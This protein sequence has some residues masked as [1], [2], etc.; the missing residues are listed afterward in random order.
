MRP[1]FLLAL[2][3]LLASCSDRSKQDERAHTASLRRATLGAVRDAAGPLAPLLAPRATSLHREG[4]AYVAGS[5][6]VDDLDVRIGAR[7]VAVA[8]GPSRRAPIELSLLDARTTDVSLEDGHVVTTGVF[9]A[10]DRVVSFYGAQVEEW[11]LLR[12]A[13]APRELRWSLRA[14]HVTRGTEGELLVSDDRGNVQLRIAKPFAIDG[15]GERHALELGWDG[16]VVSIALD[17]SI[18]RYPVLVDPVVEVP[19]WTVAATGFDKFGTTMISG[20]MD[21]DRATGK[22]YLFVGKAGGTGATEDRG[23]AEWTGTAWKSRAYGGGV[24]VWARNYPAIVAAQGKVFSYGGCASTS[25]C[26]DGDFVWEPGGGFWSAGGSFPNYWRRA[27]VTV[28]GS[29]YSS[30]RVMV[31]GG[32]DPLVLGDY[33]LG[34]SSGDP[35]GLLYNRYSY[36]TNPP[37]RYG[38]ALAFDKAR[39]RVILVGGAD[40]SG[41]PIQDAWEYDAAYVDLDSGNPWTKI[42]PKTVGTVTTPCPFTA[43]YAHSMTYDHARSKVLMYGGFN[44][45]GGRLDDTWQYDG[46]TWKAY[47]GVAAGL[48]ACAP[49]ALAD[50][51]MAYDVPSGRALMAGGS[52]A[53]GVLSDKTWSFHRRGGTCTTGTQCD[54][55]YCVDGTCCESASCGTCEQCDSAGSPGVCAKVASGNKDSDSCTPTT[56][57]CDGAGGCKLDNGQSCASSGASSCISGFCADGFCCNTACGGACDTCAKLKGASIDGTCTVLAKSAKA[58]GEPSCSPFLCGGAATCPTTCAADADCASGSYCAKDGTCKT[59]K[60]LGAACAIATDCPT[61]GCSPCDTGFCVDGVCCD[62]LCT[63]TCNA[64]KASL[65]ATGL[66]DGKCGSAADGV[67]PHNDCADARTVT[68]T[69]CKSDGACNGSGA[70]RVYAKGTKCGATAITC[71]DNKASGEQCNGLGDC[72]KDAAPSDCFPG[73]CTT[74][75]G[76]TKKCASDG[77]CATTG[78]FCDTAKGECVKA[79]L[80]GE[81]CTVGTQCASKSCVDGVCC[82]RPCGGQCE[83]CDVEGSKGTCVSVV[84]DPHGAREK[85]ATGD[86]ANPCKAA[87]CDGIEPAKCLGFATS[88]V[89]CRTK[90]CTDGVATLSAVCDG[91][92][93]CP[94]AETKTCKPYACDTDTCK[95]SCAANT[96]CAAG[97]ICSKTGECINAGVCDGDHTVTSADGKDKTDC[98][99]YRCSASGTCRDSCATTDECAAG[100]ICDSSA[101]V[102]RCVVP[103]AAVEDSGGCSVRRARGGASFGLVIAALMFVRRR[104]RLAP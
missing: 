4:L 55:G 102:G 12:D 50:A 58:A 101:G 95:T 99:P 81:A 71:T 61:G 54:T 51:P 92:G 63:G 18:T 10:T 5:A 73:L 7:S 104:R 69:S 78:A 48:P 26:T 3:A 46:A 41:V 62:S 86:A 57:T 45:S 98:T 100:A 38:A 75:G 24:P 93:E 103:P 94:K 59:K 52:K 90:G 20:G 33:P 72:E 1:L 56:S 83:A 77:E 32:E 34:V 53:G 37:A 14:E 97:S 8:V 47:C 30:D 76:C 96:D 66:D 84:G 44:A 67:D 17:P 36:T 74:S 87:R 91:R 89:S 85:C 21:Y 29:S 6:A 88:A 70:C 39:N 16:S 25:S 31:V 68:P 40:Q 9:T 35:S 13:T 15:A 80:P 23:M 65:K 19:I 60:V 43:R 49:G 22:T 11:L 42:C 82:N 64:C 2:A 79:R 27:A 28:L